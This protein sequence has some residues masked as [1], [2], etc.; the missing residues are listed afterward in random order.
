[1]LEESLGKDKKG[2]TVFYGEPKHIVETSQKN[3]SFL[4]VSFDG[5]PAEEEQQLTSVLTGLGQNSHISLNLP[6]EDAQ[7]AKMA[8]MLGLQRTIATIAYLWD[9]NFVTQGAVQN[10]KEMGDTIENTDDTLEKLDKRAESDTLGLYYEPGNSS[11]PIADS[12][13]ASETLREILESHSLG[14]LCS[15]DNTFIDLAYYGHPGADIDRALFNLSSAINT[16]GPMP[17]KRTN[18]NHFLNSSIDTLFQATMCMFL[19]FQ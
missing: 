15:T 6:T 16:I 12:D 5:I 10:Y 17:I 11:P 3:R 7:T 18:A 14:K 4:S 2:I 8:F 19:W 1:M 9:I 13:N